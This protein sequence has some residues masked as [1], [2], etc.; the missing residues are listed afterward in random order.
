MLDKNVDCVG[1]VG[2][3]NSARAL[4]AYLMS[5]GYKVNIYA[6]NPLKAKEIPKTLTAI[7]KIEGKFAFNL[8][9]S[10]LKE[11]T[12][13]STVIFVATV[14]T[15]YADVAKKIY[16]YLTKKNSIILFSGKL[17]GVCEFVTVLK[18]YGVTDIP[19]LETDAIFA[20]RIKDKDTIWVKGFKKWNIYTAECYSKTI[21][22]GHILE[23][24]FPYLKP[25]DNFIQRGLLDFGAMAHSLIM[26]INMNEIDRHH[27]FLFY[28]EGF[29]EHTFCLLEEMEKERD[30]L[31]KA[32]DTKMISLIDLLDGYYQCKKPT[33]RET[34]LN[35]PNYKSS[36]SPDELDNRYVFED[37]GNTLV[38]IHYLAKKADMYLPLIESL[39][40]L[41]SILLNTD[42]LKTGRTL[43]KLGLG[44]MTFEEIKEYIV[45]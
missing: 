17:G 6:R 29:S 30:R 20:C 15:A 11:L 27:K 21:K 42:F 32:Y 22:Y 23:E 24:F 35:V 10:D 39:I 28:Y 9:T 37:V 1:I 16:P 34:L 7:D 14:T 8:I 45:S 25:A 12:E 38:P 33:L 3:G 41:A 13:K 4:S 5:Q 18:K 31:A 44:D 19:V 43:E 36:I 40:S 26:L 2:A